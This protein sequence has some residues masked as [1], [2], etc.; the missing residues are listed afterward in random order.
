MKGCLKINLVM[1]YYLTRP[2]SALQARARME[3]AS[4]IG[5][6]MCMS[7]RRTRMP[8]FDRTQSH[9]LLIRSSEFLVGCVFFFDDDDEDDARGAVQGGV[10]VEAREMRT[11]PAF[12]SMGALTQFMIRPSA[13]FR[14]SAES[15]ET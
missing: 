2:A 10:A 3:S 6:L 12:R 15:C 11:L 4:V 5:V 8:L 14:T 1:I 9:I 7:S 13:D